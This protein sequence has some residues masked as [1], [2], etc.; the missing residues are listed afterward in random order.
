MVLQGRP[1][2]W[3]GQ[4]SLLP[5]SNRQSASHLQDEH[6]GQACGDKAD[7]PQNYETEAREDGHAATDEDVPEGPSQREHARARKGD[8]QWQHGTQEMRTSR[9]LLL[10]P[11]LP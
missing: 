9:L 11:L 6:G 5:S 10:Q 3:S 2:T 1:A 4:A 8:Q 7:K